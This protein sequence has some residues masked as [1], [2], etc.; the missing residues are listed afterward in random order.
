M[1]SKAEGEKFA[2]LDGNAAAGLLS[3]LFAVDVTVARITC[4]GCGTISL[5]GEVSVYGG[6]MGAVFR[7]SHCDTAMIRLVRTKAG[8]W[9]DMQGAKNLFASSVTI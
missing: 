3:E 7:C 5:V 9:L 4:G 1:K 8:Y 6:G 2:P